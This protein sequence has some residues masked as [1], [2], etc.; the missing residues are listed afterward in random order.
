MA[1]D[2]VPSG[3]ALWHNNLNSIT[4]AAQLCLRGW[5]EI[6]VLFVNFINGY[7]SRVVKY[8]AKNNTENKGTI[9]K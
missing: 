9:F 5:N 1:N 8:A 6:E 3:K 2:G 7:V 4:S